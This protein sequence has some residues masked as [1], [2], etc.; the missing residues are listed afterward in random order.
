MKQKAKLDQYVGLA[1]RVTLRDGIWWYSS[2][3]FNLR[4]SSYWLAPCSTPTLIGPLQFRYAHPKDG[5]SLYVG[6]EQL[7]NMVQLNPL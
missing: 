4:A 3:S 7:Q 1:V 2:L 6:V 5:T